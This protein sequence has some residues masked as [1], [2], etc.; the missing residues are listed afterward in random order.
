M[1]DELDEG[2][3]FPQK[4]GLAVALAIGVLLLLI[5]PPRGSTPPAP[6]TIDG[7]YVADGAPALFIEGTK[8]HVMQE[9]HLTLPVS[10]KYIKGWV[11]AVEGGLAAES[12]SN[13]AVHLRSRSSQQYFALSREGEIA[14]SRPQFDVIDPLAGVAFE[15]RWRGERCGEAQQKLVIQTTSAASSAHSSAVST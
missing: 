11:L 6:P 8:L 10:L 7:C 4:L 2:F 12:R 5:A 1:T 9:P 13:Q 3:G 15:Y 14:R